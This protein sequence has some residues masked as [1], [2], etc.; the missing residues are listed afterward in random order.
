M[1]YKTKEEFQKAL[2]KR[3][4]DLK[5]DKNSALKPRCIYNDDQ[6]ITLSSEGF[7]TPCC[8]LDDE[9]YRVQPWVDTFFQ[10]HLNIENNENIEDIFE[11]K[12]WEDFW[13]MLINN[14]DNAPPV[15]YEYCASSKGDKESIIENEDF[16]IE[17]KH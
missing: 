13:E 11:S 7:F 5:K 17:R 15:C 16:R 12:E 14:P 4:N 9:L 8:W 2:I 6:E 10:P 3:G 1:K